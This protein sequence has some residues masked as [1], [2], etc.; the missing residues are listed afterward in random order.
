MALAVPALLPTIGPAIAWS[1]DPQPPAAVAAAVPAFNPLNRTSGKILV[2]PFVAVNPNDTNPWV[3]KSV[4]QSLVAD[5]TAAAPDRILSTDK[6][7]PTAEDALKIARDLGARFLVAGGFFSSG[8]ELRITGQVLDVETG[9]PLVGLKVT[10]E[11]GQVFHMEDAL[12]NQVV[13][14]ISRDPRDVTR[15]EAPQPPAADMDQPPV[16]STGVRTDGLASPPP[17]GTYSPYA[18]GPSANDAYSNDYSRYVF[19]SP[20]VIYYDGY[21]SPYC[22]PYGS[23]Y[24]CAYPFSS[25]FGLGLSFADGWGRGFVGTNRNHDHREGRSGGRTVITNASID[26]S[27]FDRGSIDGIAVIRGSDSGGSVN[28]AGSVGRGPRVFSSEGS[29]RFQAG[30]FNGNQIGSATG[31][32]RTSAPRIYTGHGYDGRGYDGPRGGD[33]PR[34]AFPRESNNGGN[35]SANGSRSA[36]GNA[37]GGRR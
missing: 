30:N 3:G 34:A 8:N 36:G 25:G 16:P 10:G 31:F 22:A 37:G 11:S 13:A 9:Q 32:D 15:R 26:A 1:A 24:G 17:A 7:A 21:Y 12:A 5:L 6:T 28:G 2:M 35:G 4:Q 27:R 14:G 33:A 29:T 23:F 18:F 19:S 20:S